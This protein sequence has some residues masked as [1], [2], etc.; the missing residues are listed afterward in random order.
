MNLS[1]KDL[2]YIG[3]T[4]FGTHLGDHI[5]DNFHKTMQRGGKNEDIIKHANDK[6]HV[7]T[8]MVNHSICT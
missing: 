3:P 7:V 4:Y 1:S 2:T 5:N 8:L 6:S